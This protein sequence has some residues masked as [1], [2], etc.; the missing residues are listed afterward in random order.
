LPVHTVRTDA[1]EFLTIIDPPIR[2]DDTQSRRDA[3]AAAAREYACS[4]ESVVREFPDQWLGWSYL[5]DAPA[6]QDHHE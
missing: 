1:G 3:S 4:L 6:D 2:V 5:E